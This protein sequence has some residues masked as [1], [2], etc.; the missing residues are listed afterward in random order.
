LKYPLLSGG[1]PVAYHVIP[2]ELSLLLTTP[3][4]ECIMTYLSQ[5]TAKGFPEFVKDILVKIE[6]HTLVDILDGPGDEKLDILTI[7]LDGKRCLTQCKHISN[8][9]SKCRGDDL[10]LMVSACIRKNCQQALF[11]TN[12]DLTI[13]AKKYIVDNEYSKGWPLQKLLNIDYLNGYKIWEKIHANMDV[14]N[15]WFGGLGQSHGLRNFKFDISIHKLPY[16]PTDKEDILG[17][18]ISVLIEKSMVEEVEKD[19]CYKSKVYGEFEI[20]LKRWLQFASSLDINYL[21]PEE[22]PNYNNKPMDCLSIEVNITSDAT[23]SPNNIRK[24]VIQHLLDNGLENLPGE[25]WWHIVSSRSTSFVFIHDINEPRQ[26]ALDSA[27][28]FLKVKDYNL[29]SELYHCSLHGKDFII[30]GDENETGYYTHTKSGC[31]II[32]YFTQ[33]VAP[34]DEFNYKGIQHRQTEELKDFTFRV[35]PDINWRIMAHLTN[36]LPSEWYSFKIDNNTL[37]WCFSKETDES[38]VIAVDREIRLLGFQLKTIRSEDLPHVLENIDMSYSE[39]IIHNN[40]KQLRFPIA[41]KE[42]IFMVSKSF[43]IKKK[44]D[45]DWFRKL[46]KYKI[47]FENEWGRH[48]FTE[49]ELLRCR[50]FE[51]PYILCD[52]N[53]MRGNRMLDINV[54]DSPIWVIMRFRTGKIVPS[55]KIVEEAIEEFKKVFQD[56]RS[57]FA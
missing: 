26:I 13:Q 32:Q 9:Q 51:L 23:Y 44:V 56:I 21:P 18:M 36:L 14:L 4:Q 8:H 5:I 49:E 41:L 19:I 48:A 34:F 20:Q 50:N 53:N 40:V 37:A 22:D 27:E 28:T 29:C 55:Q 1:T 39:H 3:K 31:H 35:L 30:D 52:I 7:T 10:D 42:R 25:S 33:R 57:Q 54:W 17:N 6:G 11:V 46:A 2:T 16:C 45:N 43:P 24:K 15:K 12:G 38:Q 47:N